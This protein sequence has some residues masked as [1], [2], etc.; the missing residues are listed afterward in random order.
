MENSKVVNARVFDHEPL[1]PESMLETREILRRLGAA[2][3]GLIRNALLERSDDG[4]RP[5][6]AEIIYG[7]VVRHE[8]KVRSGAE[9]LKKVGYSTVADALVSLAGR[10]R[11]VEALLGGE[12][13]MSTV[14]KIH[15]S[16]SV[17]AARV[18]EVHSLVERGTEGTPIIY[19]DENTGLSIV[20]LTTPEHCL[21]D[22]VRLKSCLADPRQV[23][24][25]LD[26]GG[27]YSIRKYGQGKYD[28]EPMCTIQVDEGAGTVVQ[29]RRVLNKPLTR[30]SDLH[31]VLVDALPQIA[32]DM[33][34]DDDTPPR[35][36]TIVDYVSN[37]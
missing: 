11:S 6:L 4:V 25:Y 9:P 33:Y 29:A 2:S 13:S 21:L 34:R 31:R 23:R 27:L 28:I 22:G 5:N 7:M 18:R 32:E 36:L 12:A 16:Q 20:K 15:S 30:G 14:L 37:E 17:A 26:G 1:N 24:R 35:E 19:S 10:V 3:I 8:R